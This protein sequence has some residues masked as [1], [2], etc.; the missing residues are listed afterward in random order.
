MVAESLPVDSVIGCDLNGLPKQG[1]ILH[2]VACGRVV[3][4]QMG[5][6]VCVCWGIICHGPPGLFYPPTLHHS[7]AENPHP[8]EIALLPFHEP[9]ARN[10]N[11]G[12]RPTGTNGWMLSI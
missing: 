4:H 3:I 10:V 5:R 8:L 1:E 9:H 6:T 2:L 11:L 7:S 12:G